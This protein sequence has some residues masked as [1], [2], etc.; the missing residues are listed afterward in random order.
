LSACGVPYTLRGKLD[1]GRK[2][3]AMCGVDRFFY[4]IL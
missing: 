3:G 4:E 1:M 2:L